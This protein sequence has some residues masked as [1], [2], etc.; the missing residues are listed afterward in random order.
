MKAVNLKDP[1]SY[2]STY[3]D[4]PSLIIE[5]ESMLVVALCWGMGG[6]G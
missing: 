3:M 2:Y 5:I 6:N 4:C 1:I